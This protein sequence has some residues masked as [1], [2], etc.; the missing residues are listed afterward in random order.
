MLTN[1]HEMILSHDERQKCVASCI[2]HLKQFPPEVGLVFTG[3]SGILVGILVAT[4]TRRP[5]A[6][7]RKENESSHGL[8]VEGHTFSKYVII[9][10]FI[11]SGNTIDRILE[12][13]KNHLRAKCI[14]VILHNPYKQY[15]GSLYRDLPIFKYNVPG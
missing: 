7:V 15:N 5:F 4:E 14:G 13:V 12:E 11:S 8:P 10:D 6:I 1:Y 9:D 3:L 2:K